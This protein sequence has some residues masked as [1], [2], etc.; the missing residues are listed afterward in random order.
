LS[1]FVVFCGFN[2][3]GKFIRP[4]IQHLRRYRRHH[5]SFNRNIETRLDDLQNLN[6]RNQEE[7][8]RELRETRLENERLRRRQQKIQGVGG[9]LTAAQF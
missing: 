7:L 3:V 4:N 2:L 9:A 1:F 5:N 6:V 8:M